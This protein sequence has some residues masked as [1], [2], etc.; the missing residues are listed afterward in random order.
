MEV[1]KYLLT[2]LTAGLKENERQIEREQHHAMV[3]WH[4]VGYCVELNTTISFSQSMRN[5]LYAL[6]MSSFADV[7]N[8][9]RLAAT[10]S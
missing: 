4:C 2:H 3:D 5:I 8:A 9:L 1:P 7:T 6:V 10:T